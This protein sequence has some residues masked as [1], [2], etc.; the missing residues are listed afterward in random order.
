MVGMFLILG[1]S[2][3][4][5]LSN[6]YTFVTIFCRTQKGPSQLRNNFPFLV[7]ATTCFKIRL[8]SS[9]VMGFPLVLYLIFAL[10]F[11]M[12]SFIWVISLTSYIM[13]V[14]LFSSTW[15]PLLLKCS[16]DHVS[17]LTST[18]IYNYEMGI[19]VYECGFMWYDQNTSWRCSA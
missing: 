4:S 1:T 17:M 13:S 10:C 11:S 2:S 14:E 19:L 9:I 18:G 16:H 8:P 5:K 7:G 3:H 15:L 12:N 6:F